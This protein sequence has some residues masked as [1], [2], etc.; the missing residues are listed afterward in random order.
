MLALADVGD[1]ALVLLRG[2]ES[3]DAGDGGD[4]QRVPPGQQRSRGRVPELVQ[5]VVDVRILLDVGVGARDVGLR[6]VVVV[7]A[8]EVLDGVVREEL[9]EL[10]CELGGEGLVV[11]EHQGG[12]LDALDDARHRE[13]LAAARDAE[14]G[15]VSQ[16][17][18]DTVDH[19]I[20]GLRLVAGRS[21]LGGYLEVGHI[22]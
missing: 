8:D 15:L 17:V 16:P 18:V 9:L 6:L 14:Q 10:G 13:G 11:C 19:T 3:E 1:E 5:F 21:E 4:Y 2:A 12:P 22:R 7:V 20:Y